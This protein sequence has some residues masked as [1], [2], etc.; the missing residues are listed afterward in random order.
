MK[1]E[2]G[3]TLAMEYAMKYGDNIPLRYKHP[4]EKQD[5][6]GNTVAMLLA[7]H[8]CTV[9]GYWC[10]DPK[11]QNKKGETVAMIYAKYNHNIG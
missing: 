7:K 8:G 2:N 4:S 9:Y 5:D 11:I 10:H 6:D 1:F 3:R